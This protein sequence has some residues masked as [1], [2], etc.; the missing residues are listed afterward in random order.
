MAISAIELLHATERF[1]TAAITTQPL[2]RAEMIEQQRVQLISA[3]ARMT[4]INPITCADMLETLDPGRHESP[5]TQD[6]R[7]SLPS[8]LL[9]LVASD[10]SASTSHGTKQQS[11]PTLYDYLTDSM[12][13]GLASRDP[14]GTGCGCWQISQCAN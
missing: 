13:S 6:A 5:F 12:W 7:A 11:I 8:A 2:R 14:L 3:W 1:L 10:A 4:D 9:D